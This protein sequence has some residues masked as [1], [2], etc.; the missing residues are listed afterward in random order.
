MKQL[1]EKILERFRSIPKSISRIN[2]QEYV[3]FAKN[4][5]MRNPSPEEILG[6]FAKNTSE[7][8]QKLLQQ[9]LSQTQDSVQQYGQHGKETV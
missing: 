5:N 9:L 1:T 7:K 3:E 4:N 6:K 2:A 8:A